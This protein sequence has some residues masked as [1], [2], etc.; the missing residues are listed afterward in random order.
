[1]KP[2]IKISK[3]YGRFNDKYT[4]KVNGKESHIDLTDKY[5]K[6]IHGKGADDIIMQ[7]GSGT[8]NPIDGAP[9]YFWRPDKWIKRKMG[10]WSDKISDRTQDA[11]QPDTMWDSVQAALGWGEYSDEE[12]ERARAEG[13]LGGMLTTGMEGAI[14]GREKMEGFIDTQLG[15]KMKS[16]DLQGDK[17]DLQ[18]QAIS[19]GGVQARRAAMA[20]ANQSQGKFAASGAV[21][22]MN[23]QMR[24]QAYMLGQQRQMGREGIAL[25]REGIDLQRDQAYTQA[26]VDKY[27]VGVD[28]EAALAR[29]LSDYMSATGGEAPEEMMDMFTNYLEDN[30]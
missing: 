3:Q 5:I 23:D 2:H 11:G 13:Q 25:G 9:E 4:G 6:Q 19:Q 8:L 29:M 21:N 26:E 14:S 10:E 16:F 27:K 12:R 24:Q 22:Q 17:L 18:D 30:A 7:R 15:E 1:M 28:T 20:Q